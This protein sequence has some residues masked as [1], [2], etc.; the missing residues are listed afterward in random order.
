MHTGCID[1]CSGLPVDGK[2]DEPRSEGDSGLLS[3][4]VIGGIL[5]EVTGGSHRECFS[6][7]EYRD[8]LMP[9]KTIKKAIESIHFLRQNLLISSSLFS[10]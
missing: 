9:A 3:G 10:P 8:K 5:G 2:S 6:R 1:G 4:G 7:L